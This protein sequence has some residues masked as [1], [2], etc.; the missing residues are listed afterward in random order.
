MSEASPFPVYL[1]DTGRMGTCQRSRASHPDT[2]HPGALGCGFP[3]WKYCPDHHTFKE[4][5]S[6]TEG[7]R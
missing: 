2:D 3:D 7:T 1:P 5:P 6:R 4:K